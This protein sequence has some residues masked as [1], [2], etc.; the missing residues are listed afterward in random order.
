MNLKPLLDLSFDNATF[1]VIKDVKAFQAEV[2]K[3]TEV[4]EPVLHEHLTSLDIPGKVAQLTDP[5]SIM[6]FAEGV[7]TLPE[8]FLEK[9]ADVI[10]EAYPETE[11]Q[12]KTMYFIETY[13]CVRSAAD[14]YVQDNLKQRVERLL[15]QQKGKKIIVPPSII[16]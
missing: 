9:L 14:F 7:N 12:I 16:T 2:E 13:R 11:I 5:Q 10:D 15:N 3:I 1:S 6:K 8:G 4:M